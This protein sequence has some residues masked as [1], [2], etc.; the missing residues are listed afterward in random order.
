MSISRRSF[1]SRAG[2]GSS[3]VAPF[4]GGAVFAGARSNRGKPKRIIH[5]VAD[6]MSSG[7]LAMGDQLSRLVRGRPLSWMGL[8]Q[9]E[10]AVAA[11][12]ETRSLNSL[13]TDSAAAS[14]SWGSGSRVKNGALNMLPDGRAL[15]TLSELFGEMGW[16]RGLV[17][18]TEITH[19]TPAG[20]TV[21]IESRSSADT[22]A[23]QYLERRV[24]VLLGGGSQY[25]DAAKRGDKRDVA[26]EF[27]AWGYQ[28]IRGRDALMKAPLSGRWL[29]TFASGHLPYTVDRDHREDLQQKVP[30]LAE[31]TSRALERLDCYGSFLLQVEGGRVDHGAHSSDAGAM[32]FDQLAF[33][34]ALDVCLQYQRE[35]GD[36]LL[37]V[38]TDHGNSN[39][40]L[41]GMGGDYLDSPGLFANLPHTT[42]S[43]GS[44][45]DRL[46]KAAGAGAVG[47]RLLPDGK[48][49]REVLVVKPAVVQEVLEGAVGYEV[50]L[51]IARRFAG[52]LAGD[53]QPVFGALDSRSAQLGQLLGNY[54][55]IGWTGTSHTSDHVTLVATGPGA[56]R[57]GGFIKNTDV[58]RIYTDLA[59][60]RHR[61]PELPLMAECGPSA[62]MVEDLAFV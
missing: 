35:Q 15:R 6:G 27:E 47:T 56:D 1:L 9:K 44:I 25:F 21:N 59:G 14:S 29:G 62:Q 33:D 11:L 38:T 36:T 54:Y 18:T 7:T 31:M 42:C 19:A 41:N 53:W 45:Q 16:A 4:L 30:T 37:V 26:A 49:E 46:V 58:F 39:P 57:F 32:L 2:L 55:G 60:I 22:I 34:E 17:T 40:A 28:V 52:Y 61:N 23:L 20:F 51:E 43:F 8:Y 48:T 13:V 5:M 3:A 50:P 10:N 12:M 24:E